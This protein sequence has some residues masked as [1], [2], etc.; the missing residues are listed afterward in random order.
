MIQFQ[1]GIWSESFNAFRKNI[2]AVAYY[3]IIM[4]VI[5]AISEHLRQTTGLFIAEALAAAYLA[6]PI[7]RTVLLKNAGWKQMSQPEIAKRVSP[8]VI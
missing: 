6:I 3:L 2:D 4:F 8:F 1:R 5:K 7:H